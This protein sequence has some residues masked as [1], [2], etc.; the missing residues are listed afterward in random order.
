GGQTLVRLSSADWMD[1]N[2]FRRIELSFPVTDPKLKRRVVG[3]GLKPYLD[4]NSQ[5]WEMQ[6]DGTFKRLKH[7]RRKATCAQVE[8]MRALAK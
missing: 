5:A 4:D 3:E 6:P 2:F 1:R 7:G 8:L